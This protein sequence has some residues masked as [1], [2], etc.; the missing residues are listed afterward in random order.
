[1]PGNALKKTARFGISAAIIT[2]KAAKH[3]LNFSNGIAKTFLGGAKSMANQFAK[4]AE[5]PSIGEKLWDGTI[6]GAN[7][8]FDLGIGALSDFKKKV[9]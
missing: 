6:K 8:L 3:G 2:A 5:F 1:M 7:K 4:G 9:H